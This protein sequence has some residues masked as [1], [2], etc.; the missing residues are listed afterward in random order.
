MQTLMIAKVLSGTT[1]GL[2]GTLIEVEVDV[3]SRGFPTFNLVGLPDKAVE[4]AKDRVR[5]A[6]V[7]ASFEMPDSRITVNLAPADI[8][9]EGS[10]FDLP[11]AVG[12]LSASGIIDRDSLLSSLFVGELSL[13]GKLRPVPGMISIALM[14]KEKKIKSLFVPLDNA[15]E[16]A[17]VENISIY[18]VY[19]INDL[20]LHLNKTRLI[21]PYPPIQIEHLMQQSVS[22]FD[23]ADIRGQEQAKRALEIAAAGFHNIHL[24]GVPGAGKT[25][26]SR[27]FPSILPVMTKDEIL[28]VTKMYSVA[29]LCQDRGFILERPFRSPHHTTS[30]IGLIGGGNNPK[31]GEISLAHRGVL[32]LDEFPEFPR[33]VLESLRQPLED[34]KVTIS[35]AAG[36]VTFPSRFLLLAASNPCPC[37]YLGHPK[38]KCLCMPG[39]ILRYQKRLSGPLLDR[40]DLHVDVL[41]VEEEKLTSNVKAEQSDVIKKR[42][43]LA[44]NKQQ[45]RFKK[46]KTKTNGEMNTNEI[47]QLCVLDKEAIDMLK[48]AVSRLSLSARSYFKIIKIAQTISDLE[49]T[50]NIKMTHIAEA[51]QYRVKEN[52]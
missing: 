36:S 6:I 51:L 18:P 12:I 31:P 30:R 46:N 10:L 2:D 38:K 44:R 15:K 35:R 41:P 13:E 21:S 48:K 43:M 49:N 19:N 26:L 22:E 52:E 4:E 24:K 37:G 32:F 3:A 20:I 28:E 40:I 27:A 34:G 45:D 9:K 25:M 23:F 29:G 11:I 5:T 1:I 7:N 14:A 17:L 8:P 16:A 50:E 42:V 47:R 39:S 33:S